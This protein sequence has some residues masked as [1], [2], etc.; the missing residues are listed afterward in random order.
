MHFNKN[1]KVFRKKRLQRLSPKIYFPINIFLCALIYSFFILFFYSILFH[2]FVCLLAT[3]IPDPP[4]APS[5]TDVGD[6]WCIMKWEPPAY[7]GGTPILG[8]CSYSACGTASGVGI[9]FMLISIE[10]ILKYCI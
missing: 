5:V 1:G 6:D 3:D 2:F 4:V 8:N 9:F 10:C 7:D